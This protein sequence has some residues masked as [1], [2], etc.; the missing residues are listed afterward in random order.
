MSDTPRTNA[1]LAGMPDQYRQK[2]LVFVEYARELERELN[3]AR[4]I[5]AA[6]C[7]KNS[8]AVESWKKQP[9][10]KALFDFARTP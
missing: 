3:Q 6:F 1:N 2:G 10:V 7:E 4:S 9:H 5:V 8:F